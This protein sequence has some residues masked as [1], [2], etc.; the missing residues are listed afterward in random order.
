MGVVGDG[1][2]GNRR[3]GRIVSEELGKVMIDEVI[4]SWGLGM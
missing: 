3:N 4:I 1:M 2:K